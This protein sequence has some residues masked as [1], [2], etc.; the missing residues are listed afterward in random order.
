MYVDQDSKSGKFRSSVDRCQLLTIS[1]GADYRVAESHGTEELRCQ[2]C[3]GSVFQSGFGGFRQW[4]PRVPRDRQ[5][6]VKLNCVRHLQ[7]LDALSRLIVGPECVCSHLA[8]GV[9]RAPQTT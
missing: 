2:R 7:P 5:C 4:Y 3:Q 9:Y 1:N 6:S 8:G